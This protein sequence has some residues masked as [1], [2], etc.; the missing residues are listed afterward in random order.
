MTPLE[1]LRIGTRFG[2]EAIGFGH[3][4]GSLE[5]G[6]LADLIVLDKNPLADIHNTESIR[7]VMKN[8]RIFQGEDLTEIWPRKRPLPEQW[9]ARWSPVAEPSQ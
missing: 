8:G 6:K 3:D 5:P 9:W 2:A 1:A 4:L 7:W